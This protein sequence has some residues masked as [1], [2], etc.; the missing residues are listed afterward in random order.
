MNVFS[1]ALWPGANTGTLHTRRSFTSRARRMTS[2][3][4]R[5]SAL[6]PMAT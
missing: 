4:M 2:T 1:V 6:S 3:F 5:G